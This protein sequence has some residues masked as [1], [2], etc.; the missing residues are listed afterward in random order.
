MR[1]RALLA[2]SGLLTISALAGCGRRGVPHGLDAKTGVPSASSAPQKEDDKE[3]RGLCDAASPT[4]TITFVHVN[5][6]HAHWYPPP[7]DKAQTSPYARLRG[8]FEQ[9]RKET[10]YALFTNAGDDFEKG[11]VA[12][13]LSG[14]V[15]NIEVTQ[16]MR[17]DVRVLG[18]HDLA[19]GE[20]IAARHAADPHALVLASN[21][22]REGGGFPAKEYGEL[23]IGCLRVGFIGLMPQPFDEHDKAF[24]GD[25]LPALRSDHDVVKRAR[26]LVDAHRASVQLFVVVSH[27][28]K[29]AEEGL[30]E[31]VPGVD[32]VLGGHSHDAYDTVKN[33]GGHTALIQAGHSAEHVARL[34]VT[35]D[36]AQR[37]VSKI[38]YR[39]LRNDGALPVDAK[40]QSAIEDVQRRFA[41]H[42]NQPLG[43]V[44][45]E[46]KRRDAAILAGR[47]AMVKLHADGAFVREAV[48]AEGGSIAAG[49]LDQQRIADAYPVQREPPNTPG[50]TSFYTVDVGVAEL[51]KMLAAL[52]AGL[53]WAG[54]KPAT[55][56]GRRSVRLAMP[57]A[58]A[59]GSDPAPGGVK[60]GNPTFGCEAWEA[61]EAY[62]RSRGG[63]CQHVD[64]DTAV[65]GC[66]PTRN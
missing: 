11:A 50:F 19:W 35:F 30:A 17:F 2:L 26:A 18:N 60:L 56:H 15:A 52:P 66:V 58:L 25:Y 24:A 37:K 65:P 39:L 61:V 53:R 34:D 22:Q 10:P 33:V 4:Q 6:L 23:T 20:G 44:S 3:A 21:L 14:G 51:G 42:A 1:P 31:H 8:Y 46:V 62:A 7:A 28:G 38:D 5:D 48:V 64:Q 54:P 43:V 40:V 55:F 36:K 27:L 16:A 45:A 29:D 63:L 49:P 12:E 13:L 47:A 9:V 32:V 59:I 57:K 41:P